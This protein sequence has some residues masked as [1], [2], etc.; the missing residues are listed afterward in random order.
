MDV[1]EW[2]APGFGIVKTESKSG[3]TEITSIK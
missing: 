3:K 1:V 2:F